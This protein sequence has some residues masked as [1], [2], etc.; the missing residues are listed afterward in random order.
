MPTTLSQRDARHVIQRLRDGLVPERGLDAFAVGIERRRDEM[1]RMLEM[2]ADGEG[3]VKFLRGGYGCGKTFLAR[4][5]ALDARQKGF[6]TSF[7]VISDSDLR[8]YKFDELYREIV[9]NLSTDT[10]PEGGALADVLDRWIGEI[11]EKLISVLGLEPDDDA[12]ADEVESRIAERLQQMTRG[13]LQEEFIRAVQGIY[14]A[15]QS[16]DFSDASELLSWLSGSPHVSA[17]GG[18]KRAGIKQDIDTSDAL[19]FLRGILEIVKAAGYEGMVVVIDEIETILRTRSDV[20]DKSLNGLRQIVDESSKFEGLL[21]TM[22]GTPKFFD[23]QRGVAGLEPFDQRIRFMDEGDYTNLRQ[24]QLKL[25]PFDRERLEEVAHKVREIYPSEHPSRLRERIDDEFIRSLVDEVT[26]GFKGDVG[27]VPRQ[28]LRQ[29]V[30]HMDLVDDQSDYDPSD[31]L[32]FEPDPDALRPEERET[33]EGDGDGDA[34]GGDDGRGL[35]MER[36]EW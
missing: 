5:T 20:R 29:L 33:L 9:S 16:G 19:D 14:D 11:E 12:F 7:V 4:L 24:A 3:L 6:A 35:E 30:H 21:W 15:K 8:F 34:N 25:E 26:E 17:Y 27:V 32:G 28:F 22:T 36:E 18:K 10:C 31:A 2:A 1:H 23:S 13:G